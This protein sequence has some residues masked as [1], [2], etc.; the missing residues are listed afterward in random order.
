MEPLMLFDLAYLAIGIASL[1]ACWLF[2]LVCD[3]L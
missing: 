2:T 3:S 1:A